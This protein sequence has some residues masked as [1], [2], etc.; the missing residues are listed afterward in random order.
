MGCVLANLNQCIPIMGCKV[1]FAVRT[2]SIF[3][4]EF[5]YFALLDP[6][7]LI[8]RSDILNF[9]LDSLGVRL[10]PQ[11]FGI[12]QLLLSQS[13]YFFQKDSE[14]FWTFASTVDPRR[15]LI[16]QAVCAI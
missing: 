12:F 16:P 6:S 8:D 11:K 14:Q 2:L 10:G 4:D 15:S 1:F 5:D 3:L 9:E 13:F 7:V